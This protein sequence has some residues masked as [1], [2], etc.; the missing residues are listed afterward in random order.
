MD[1]AIIK[2]YHIQEQ[3]VVRQIKFQFD[4]ETFKLEQFTSLDQIDTPENE[5]LQS[6]DSMNE[7]DSDTVE[8]EDDKI[9]IE[10]L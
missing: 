6:P 3:R 1:T 10:L 8:Q 9:A 2:L 7:I 5:R 4:D